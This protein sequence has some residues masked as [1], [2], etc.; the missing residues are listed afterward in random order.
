MLQLNM[1]LLKL[2]I[3]FITLNITLFAQ[4]NLTIEEKEFIKSHPK[5]VLGIGMWEPYAIQKDDGTVTGYDAEVL[6]LINKI[7]GTNFQLTTG[8]WAKMRIRA[9][10]KEID[11]LSN[12][13]VTKERK[14]Y[15][16]QSNT[17]VT[18]Q[19]LIFTTR[20]N[21]SNIHTIQD[22]E[23]K[24]IGTHKSNILE[25]R[26]A[27]RFTKSTIV[28]FDTLDEGINALVTGKIDAILGDNILL[29]RAIKL[30]LPYLKANV[31]LDN[32][33]TPLVFSVRKDWPEA[34]SIIN[35]ALESIGKHK[36]LLIKNRWFLQKTSLSNNKKLK[37][38]KEETLYLKEK[39]QITMCID[40]D[41]M[42]FE[43]FDKNSNHIGLTSDFF[44]IFRE[45][46][47]VPIKTVKTDTW[48]Q[49]LEF[50]KNRKCDILS[51]A[52]E[53]PSRKK[54]LN[55][56]TPYLDAPLVLATKLDKQFVNDF[57]TLKTQKVGIPKGY[58]YLELLKNSYPNLNIVE[59]ENVKDGL[60]KVVNDELFGYVGTL[61]TIGYLFQKEFTGELKIAG[62][63][64]EK[65]AL[66]V[67][68][69]NDDKK[70]LGIFS[71]IISNIDEIKKKNILNDWIAI[72][73][74]KNVDY[75]F[76]IKIISILLIIIVTFI[77]WN[78]K[79]SNAKEKLEET[80]K[81]RKKYL[82]MI[83]KHVLISTADTKGTI[84]YVSDALCRLTGYTKDELLGKH[85]H[86]FTLEDMNSSAYKNL[87]RTIE[88]AQTWKGQIKN[89]K[90]D[91]SE[92]WSDVIITPRYDKYSKRI[93]YSAIR[94]D[95]TDKKRIEKL[96]I[97]DKLTGIFNRT[98]L[99][100]TIENELKRSNRNRDSFG[101]IL[102]D[103]DYFKKV[104]DTYGHLIGDEVL[105]SIANTL[106]DNIREI[107][108]I[109]RWGGEEFL[110][111][112]PYVDKKGIIA[113]AENL[114][115]KLEKLDFKNCKKQSGSF[116]V[117]ISKPSD[118]RDSIILRADN[119]LYRVKD[120]GRNSVLFE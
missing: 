64:D 53:T 82:K 113:F 55:F 99:D 16:N 37:F 120:T 15:F 89:S 12:T 88:K 69:R 75:G 54:Y 109:G 68:V 116:G 44:K 32:T 31:H 13:I 103:I 119:A 115:K 30:D 57:S 81:D 67:A 101:I 117:T 5:I 58:A 27:K 23:G 21:P 66:G 39:K 104:N 22:L 87:W 19:K 46:L 1:N 60:N 26:I 9:R 70:L 38:T 47:S 51:L 24:K 105:V 114:R 110:I 62:K 90:K 14:K 63:F 50:A 4:I 106:K 34:V 108:T 107:D 111:V 100:N 80:S 29:Y 20:E 85:H 41:W 2:F 112:C 92:Y 8:D 11:G 35:K 93:G 59:V 78:R 72:K 28:M 40:P 3:L 10:A 43:A 96:S 36:L 91:G 65:W 18:V 94:N 17:Y 74:E 61:L 71:K 7:T 77:Y 86:I 97:T 79:L 33:N 98:K 6:S 45:E 83:D 118:D 56:T 95:I 49:S 84:T 102:I 52:M 76:I 25:N 42:P 73:Y 48:S